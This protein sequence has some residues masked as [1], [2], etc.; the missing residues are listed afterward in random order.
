MANSIL[1]TGRVVGKEVLK[2]DAR[3][4]ASGAAR[5]AADMRPHTRGC[6][7]GKILRSPYAHA[8]IVSIDTSKAVAVKGVYA[9]VTGE[10]VT[11]ARIGRFLRDRTVLARGKVRFIGEPVA[12]VAAVDEETAVQALSLIRVEYRQLP[13]VFTPEE[14]L[15]PD[16]PTVHEELASYEDP[17]PSDRC[18]NQRNSVTI[19]R[20]DVDEAFSRAD[21][22]VEGTFITQPVHQGFIEPKACVADVDKD[23][24]LTIWASNKSPFL[25]RAMISRGLGLPLS[26]VRVVTPA[27]GGDFG[28]KGAPTIEPVCALLALKSGR[29]V[30]IA[31]STQEELATNFVRHPGVINLKVAASREGRLLG[32]E[33]EV[34]F[35]CGAYCDGI[36]GMARSCSY[37]Q[38]SYNV[39]AVRLRGRSIFTNSVPAG[40]VRAPGSPQ[41]LF[42]VESLM[43]ELARRLGLDPFEIRRLNALKAGDPAPDGRGVIGNNGLRETIDKV[44]GYVS[45]NMSERKKNRGVGVA[46]G[47][48]HTTLLEDANPTKCIVKLN[49]DG[50]AVLLTGLPDNGAGQ[51]VVL[52]QVVSEVLG[53][54]PA[55]VSVV[56]GD[57]E[58]TPFDSGP[59]GSRGTVRVCHAT[60]FA[61]EDARRQ[62]FDLAASKLEANP[63]DLEIGNRSVYVKGTSERAISLAALAGAALGSPRGAIIGTG[64]AERER[65]IAQAKKHSGVVDE[66]SFCT[67]AVQV[68]V[69]PETGQVTVL[70]YA[71][72]QDVGAAL[73]PLN[74]AGQIHGSVVAGLGYALSEELV[75]REG[76]IVNP[77]YTDYHLPA[78][79]TAP[80][81]HTILVEQPSALGPFGARGVGETS[82]T[83]VAA[84]IAN[85]IYDAV[86]VRIR[87]LPITPEKVLRAL[88][89]SRAGIRSK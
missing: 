15:A 52:A 88:G 59:G 83:P 8:S 62:I 67:H 74:V 27:V 32:I 43:D 45:Q 41:T 6:L 21:V 78:A 10:D 64:S 40:H 81:I 49:E 18:G 4:K 1:G 48:W 63:E 66:A 72:A 20:G 23:G 68:E 77:T 51:H 3:L 65:W 58:L 86:G 31:L 24:K 70:K 37:L 36:F 87:D 53:L 84:A 30:K 17:M 14:A 34:I 47:A 12:A 7:C 22:V 2:N 82:I 42:A 55:E 79:D 73:N 28:G 71:A 44:S 46:C 56:A 13:A 57:T 89:E 9:V 50:S 38:G 25:N 33:G 54:D 61:A 29:P 75:V 35:N 19:E 76:R 5:Y 85:A 26:K 60:R 80:T 16:A 11:P 39:P 69:D